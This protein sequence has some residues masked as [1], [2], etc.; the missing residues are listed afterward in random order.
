MNNL[1]PVWDS[2]KTYKTQNFAFTIFCN[3]EILQHFL[4]HMLGN[5]SRRSILP[6]I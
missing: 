1:M 5:T 3:Y 6:R 2:V 4:A